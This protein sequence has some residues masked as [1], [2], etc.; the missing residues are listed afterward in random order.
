M[1]Q[2]TT[3]LDAETESDAS[4]LYNN[5]D[6]G[7]G[8]QVPPQILF[9]TEFYTTTLTIVQQPIQSMVDQIV[10]LTTTTTS[11]VIVIPEDHDPPPS[12]EYKIMDD[13][14]IFSNIISNIS[15]ISSNI[16][17][18][19]SSNISSNI[20][21]NVSSNVFPNV[22]QAD[23]VCPICYDGFL[24]ESRCTRLSTCGHIFHTGCIEESVRHNNHTCP[25]CRR[26][27]R[28]RLE[29]K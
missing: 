1:I 6:M 20:F 23:D 19:T 7:G 4:A 16:I 15:D 10:L 12:D 29:K 26:T 21:P 8:L 22:S 25:V 2:D 13:S 14:D 9:H 17:S 5:G 3:D 18:N 28:I 11:S 27:I 24:L